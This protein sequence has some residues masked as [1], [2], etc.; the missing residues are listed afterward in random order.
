MRVGDPGQCLMGLRTSWGSPWNHFQGPCT[1][2][3]WSGVGDTYLL[4]VASEPGLILLVCQYVVQV[5]QW[6]KGVRSSLKS[7]KGMGGTGVAPG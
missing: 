1:S 7:S 2:L 6:G 4:P 5:R 3:A